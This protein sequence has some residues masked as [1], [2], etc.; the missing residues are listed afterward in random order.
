MCWVCYVFCIWRF[1]L[2][3]NGQFS[4]LIHITLHCTPMDFYAC[5]GRQL[6]LW[7]ICWGRILWSTTQQ[8]LLICFTTILNTIKVDI[9]GMPQCIL[10]LFQ[11][12]YFT[13]LFPYLV[14][15]ILFFRGVTL[16]GAGKGI[17]YYI[18]PQWHRL[19]DATVS[20]Y[21]DRSE[22]CHTPTPFVYSSYHKTVNNGLS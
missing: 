1:H 9:C 3:M 11:V 7:S 16:P 21:T 17:S 6:L 15:I 10:Y 4:Y 5:M 8:L 12:V 18:T 14:L 2:F 13:A 19:A 22:N 20:F